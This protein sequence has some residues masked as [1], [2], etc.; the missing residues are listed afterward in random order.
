VTSNMA[1]YSQ[2]VLV[3]GEG[4]RGLFQAAT[5]FVRTL[6]NISD[7]QK[8]IFY[9]LYKQAKEG[10]CTTSRPGFWDPVGRAKWDSWKKLG[11]MPQEKALERYI[12]ELSEID[13]EWEEKYAVTD[14]LTLKDP[15]KPAQKQTMGLAVSTLRGQENPE[16]EI[17]SDANKSVFDWCKEG[18]VKK[19]DFLLTREGNVNT[20]DDQ[21]M[22]LLHWACD[23]GHVDIVRYLIKN[24]ADIN[25]QDA[26]GQTPLHYAVTCDF[27]SIVKELLQCGADCSI[28]DS[29]GCQ[30]IDVAE[31]S[32]VKEL[33]NS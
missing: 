18:N 31:S 33:L 29:D 20:K 2:E 11:Y 17:I 26:D 25:A 5:E 4:L 30:P 22:T 21:E 8:L 24:K 32:K 10:A 6:K 23:R 19:L 14:D 3:N 28:T 13:P 9:G 27:L 1:K 15:G 12:Q 16:D 7:E